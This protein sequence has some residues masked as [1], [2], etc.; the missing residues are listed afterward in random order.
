MANDLF[1]PENPG[2]TYGGIYYGSAGGHSGEIKTEKDVRPVD[3]RQQTLSPF[4]SSIRAPTFRDSFPFPSH[5]T[6]S[7]SSTPYPTD[8]ALTQQY[9]LPN[10][11]PS[12][13][14]FAQHIVQ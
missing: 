2:N 5:E 14:F 12:P 8:N 13:Q 10:G 7:T 6:P 3:T 4:F 9:S 11:L 1:S